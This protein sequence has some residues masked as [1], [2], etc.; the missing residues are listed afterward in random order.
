MFE[1]EYLKKFLGDYELAGQIFTVI[2]KGNTLTLQAP[3]QS[4]YELV[5][6]LGEEFYLKQVKIVSLAFTVDEQGKVTGLELY[7]P[8]GTYTATKIKK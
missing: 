6:D 3:G 5:P 8:E 4:P 1:P 2:L 7:Q